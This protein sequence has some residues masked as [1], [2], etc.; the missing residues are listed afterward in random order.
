MIEYGLVGA[1]MAVV[2]LAA[3]DVFG[4]GVAERVNQISQQLADPLV[5]IAEKLTDT[6]ST[7]GTGG[8]GDTGGTGG[9]GDTGGVPEVFN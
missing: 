9:G 5:L 7:G 8:A 1:V 4:T 2:T 6:G 3:G